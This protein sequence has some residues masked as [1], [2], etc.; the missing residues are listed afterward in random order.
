M[1][2][3]K[4]RS[5]FGGEEGALDPAPQHLERDEPS[6]A[7]LTPRQA[8]RGILP[9]RRSAKRHEG[10]DS[11][12]SRGP[13]RSGPF[14]W[15]Q[16]QNWLGDWWCRVQG[17]L[18]R[19]GRERAFFI[20]G[21][22]LATLASGLVLAGWEFRPPGVRDFLVLAGLM[23]LVETFPVRLAGEVYA[24]PG[25]MITSAAFIIG[26][27]ALAALV[28][29]A[30]ELNAHRLRSRQ[31]LRLLLF[32]ASQLAVASSLGGFL[33]ALLSP[34]GRGAFGGPGLARVVAGLT[35]G[36][37]LHFLS[38]T[39]LV[40][41]GMAI[42]TG[43]R[44]AAIWRQAFRPVALSYFFLAANGLLLAAFYLY[45]GPSAA[46]LFIA[47]LALGRLV[48]RARRE[49]LETY[50]AMITLMAET[51]QARDPYTR[52]HSE[53]VAILADAIAEEL[54]LPE[55][56][57]IPLRYAALL[58]DVGKIAT[59]TRV[60][61][62]HG[63]L[64]PEE[65]ELI[66]A[67]TLVGY[68]ALAGV[69][70]LQPALPAVRHHHERL[71]GTG[72][73]DGLRGAEIPLEARIVAV[74]DVYD[75]LTSDRPYRR[76]FGHAEALEM[77]DEMSGRHLDSEAVK[78]LKAVLARRG[79]RFAAEQL[80]SGERGAGEEGGAAEVAVG[81]FASEVEILGREAV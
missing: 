36:S 48:F 8:V 74:A 41:L 59:P 27:P 34:V 30:G 72:Y 66:K 49:E 43:S 38:N 53:R 2:C 50:E 54:G 26:G 21:V 7:E 56:R 52:R 81:T 19:L 79:P 57:R 63:R 9:A 1:N 11:G 62:K 47:P 18:T 76:A 65:F 24:T 23:I 68:E 80:A 61:H 4:S 35:L 13:G 3:G 69:G 46:L 5:N 29:A 25:F 37:A 64:E 12:C 17:L 32:N 71:D 51:L 55:E 73:P 28:E 6:G 70:F 40:S 15:G 16:L 42:K 45:G 60:L 31:A 58:H 20:T 33:Y 75:S 77:M 67:H 44:P 14:R 78:A 22:L 39:G 10:S